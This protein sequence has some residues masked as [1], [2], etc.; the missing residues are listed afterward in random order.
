MGRTRP[1]ASRVTREKDET[2]G[3]AGSSFGG[4]GTVLNPKCD[5]SYMNPGNALKFIDWEFSCGAAG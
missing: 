3:L 5:A 2:A 1:E 4:D